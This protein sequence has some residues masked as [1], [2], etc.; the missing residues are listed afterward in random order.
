MDFD[1]FFH[2]S[3]ISKEDLRGNTTLRTLTSLSGPTK[4]L[5]E[6]GAN[7]E[8]SRL[9]IQLGHPSPNR[10]RNR[11]ANEASLLVKPF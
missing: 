5:G 3:K 11:E 8:S 10:N 2:S 6:Y 4:C 1:R 9:H 7:A